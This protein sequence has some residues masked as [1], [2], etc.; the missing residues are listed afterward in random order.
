MSDDLE[1]QLRDTLHRSDLP[2]AP[3]GLRIRLETLDRPLTERGGRKRSPI[4]WLVLA[5]IAA[6]ILVAFAGLI[7]GGRAPSVKLSTVEPSTRLST[8]RGDG[9]TFVY[10][11]DWRQISGYEHAGLHG[12]TVLAAVGIGDFNLG[13]SYTSTSVSCDSGPRWTVPD[14]GIVLVYRFGAWLGPIVPQPT[15]A[16]GPGD[17]WVSV[18]GRATVLSETGHSLVW[19]FL[20][21]PEFIEARWGPGAPAPVPSQVRAVVSSWQWTV[22]PSGTP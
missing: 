1:R 7:T 19:H 14:S 12:P 20:G 10:P 17:T 9:F 4:T 2:S 13:C 8:F 22:S 15:P 3:A 18:G 16:L 21:A 5:P 6:I 11:A